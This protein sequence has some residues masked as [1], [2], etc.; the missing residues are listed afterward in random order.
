MPQTDRR[1]STA[2]TS[3][4]KASPSD[5][6]GS[7]TTSAPRSPS[8]AASKPAT[9]PA[10]P[11]PSTAASTAE[12]SDRRGGHHPEGRHHG[13]D[14]LTDRSAPRADVQLPCLGSAAASH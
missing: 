10:P 14:L 6:S 3:N 12:S 1:R 2:T 8:S 7:P 4:P 13:V 5:V 9:S 11:S